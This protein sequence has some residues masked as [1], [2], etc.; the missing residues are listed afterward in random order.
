MSAPAACAACGA[1]VPAGAV[2]FRKDG[3]E[4]LRCP[5]CGLLFRAV[6]PTPAEL[7]EI[8]GEAYFSSAAGDTR[9][10]G[11]ADY[12]GDEPAHRALAR[13][14]LDALARHAR[15][16]CLLDVGAAAG[17][18]VD[19]AVRRGW[20]ARGVD[21]SEAMA[22]WGRRRLGVR[23]ETAA[24]A[25]AGVAAASLDAVTMWD[26]LE[27]S[28]DPLADLRRAAEALR[29]AGVLALSTGDAASAVARLSG[30]R[31]H[32][33]TPRHHTFFFTVPTLRLLLVRA[34]FELLE[35]GRP[36]ARYSL[37]YLAHKLRTAADVAPVR[38]SAAWLSRARLGRLEVPVNLGDI[39]TVY[40]RR[41]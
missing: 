1:A 32:L 25:D 30:R 21:V 5:S 9:G 19:E 16:G 8:Y 3:F 6:L 11:Y 27:H 17:F 34:G 26:Y 10:P 20:D 33:L 28:L 14:R 37:A 23:I 29:P 2:R 4:I 15:P 39:V 41:R 22:G 36:G 31:W 13:R 38:A 7:G 35:W 40:A 24:L 18:F 12:V